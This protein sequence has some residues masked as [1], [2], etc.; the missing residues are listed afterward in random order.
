MVT[1]GVRGRRPPGSSREKDRGVYPRSV[2]GSSVRGCNWG[3]ILCPLGPKLLDGLSP[4]TPVSPPPRRQTARLSLGLRIDGRLCKIL[5]KFLCP[6]VPRPWFVCVL[7]GGT[8]AVVGTPLSLVYGVQFL[9]LLRRLP[10]RKLDV[11]SV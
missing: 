8:Q 4:S 6:L 10:C 7:F 1:V 11:E 2:V 3:L 5:K 9:R